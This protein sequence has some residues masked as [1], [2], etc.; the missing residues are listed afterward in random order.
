MS[1]IGD[2]VQAV[3]TEVAPVVALVSEILETALKYLPVD[4]VKTLLDAAAI[5]RANAVA[6]AAETAKFEIAPVAEKL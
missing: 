6:N 3:E 5:K 2:V 4:Q 1:A